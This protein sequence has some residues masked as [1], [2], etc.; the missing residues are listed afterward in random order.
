MLT[1]C[2]A[3]LESAISIQ[4]EN[5]ISN[6]DTCHPLFSRNVGARR[7]RGGP[8]DFGRSVNLISTR[9]A[10]YAY[11]ITTCPPPPDFQTFLRPC[12]LQGINSYVEGL[13]CEKVKQNQ[14]DLKT[15][16]EKDIFL[17]S[18]MASLQSWSFFIFYL[19]QAISTF[20]K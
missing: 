11:H 8:L 13:K 16:K 15:K 9:G 7:G 6:L 4:F 1:F 10:D 19:N 17:G 20:K 3:I 2:F 5:S 18:K 12:K 14:L